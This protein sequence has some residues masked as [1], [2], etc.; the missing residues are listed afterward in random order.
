MTRFVYKAKVYLC[1]FACICFLSPAGLA[2]LPIPQE[3]E[4]HLWAPVYLHL[5]RYK[6]L[7]PVF[8]VQPRV[9]SN[10]RAVDQLLIR[11]WVEYAITER[12]WAGLGYT[13]R[14]TYLPGFT[15]D[16]NWVFEEL[17]YRRRFDRLRVINRFRAEDR[18]I[19]RASAM[20][21][22]LRHLAR[23][24]YL[25]GSEKHWALVAWS[26]LFVNPYTVKRGPVAGIDQWR[27]FGGMRRQ[28]NNRT[29][30]EFGYQPVFVNPSQ[31][32]IDRLNNA[33]F[34]RWDL[35]I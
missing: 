23:F 26:E 29:S 15:I 27:V 13:W 20:S 12:A 21:I 1:L 4:L 11:P 7:N 22:R 6:R 16:E 2:K 28:V 31:P 30:V 5:P 19:E 18:F 10:L 9:G 3:N 32:P 34:M 17:G 35:S 25:L 14:Q 8:E 33:I 24:E